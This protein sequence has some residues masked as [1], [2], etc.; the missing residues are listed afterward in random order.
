[1]SPKFIYHIHGSPFE[2]PPGI[3]IDVVDFEV[4]MEV[5]DKRIAFNKRVFDGN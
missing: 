5:F 3:D 2:N 4:I 1:M